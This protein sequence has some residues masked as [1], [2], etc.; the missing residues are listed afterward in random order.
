IIMK[1]VKKLLFSQKWQNQ[2]ALD[3]D[4]YSGVVKYYG[5]E[6]YEQILRNLKYKDTPD[7]WIKNIK[8]IENSDCFIFDEK[9]SSA[10]DSTANEFKIDISKIYPNIDLKET[11]HNLLGQRPKEIS[12]NTVIFKDNST[13]PLIQVLK[14]LLVW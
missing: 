5:L 4:G 9:L 3:S 10:I 8:N 6:Q 13:L 1:R 14:P 7:E 12:D 2:K 11:I